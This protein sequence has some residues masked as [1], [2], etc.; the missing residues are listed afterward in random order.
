[1]DQSLR[2]RLADRWQDRLCWDVDM[3]EYCTLRAGGRAA[4]LVDIGT[5]AELVELLEDLEQASICSRVIGR[6]SNIL[7]RDQGYPGVLIRLQGEF[8]AVQRK[9]HPDREGSIIEVGAGCSMARLLAWCEKNG[10]SGLEF[11]AGIPGTVGGA[12]R[13]NAGAWGHALGERVLEIDFLVPGSGIRSVRAKELEFSYRSLVWNGSKAELV[14]TSARLALEPGDKEEI[15]GRCRDYI[16][17]R[18]GK[19]PAGVASAGSFFKNPDQDS[20]GRLIEAAGLKG[21][22]CGRAMVSPVHANFLI[23]TGG[24][25]AADILGLMELVQDR[26]LDRF[27]VRLEPEVRII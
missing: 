12:L 16:G 4:A 24:A 21:T 5:A 6:G 13:M 2:Q 18:R 9:E 23:N 19:Q 1:M 14:I 27:G 25:S 3:A 15:A 8:D 22:R 17:R 7:V 11:M 26:V 10:L 20:A